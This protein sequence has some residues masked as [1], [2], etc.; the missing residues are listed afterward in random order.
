MAHWQLSDIPWDAFDAAK[1]RPEHLAIVRAA[2]MVEH[3]GE[4]YARYLRDVFTGDEEFQTAT[5]NWA[6]EEVQH[7][8]A[9]RR[10]AE[11][12]DPEFDFTQSF[13]LFTDGH[14]LPTGV[15]ESVRGSRCGELI[16]RCVVE[17]GTSIYYTAIKESTEEP[18]LKAICAKIAADEYRHYQLFY[19]LLQRYQQRDGINLVQ[20]LRIALGRVAEMDDNELAFAFFASHHQPGDYAQQE[21]ARRYFACAAPLYRKVHI[22]RI[23]ALILKAI[24]LKPNG[25]LS[26]LISHWGWKLWSYRTRQVAGYAVVAA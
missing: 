10:W 9:L 19:G 23:T 20:R 18:V 3:N 2:C 24:G 7:G 22:E 8:R 15:T 16:A 13:A 4:D 6:K 11:M 26:A 1:V 21:S 14:Q 17:T 25:R 5:I 12:A